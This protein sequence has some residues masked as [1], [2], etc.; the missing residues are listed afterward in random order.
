VE[1]KTP[2]KLPGMDGL[3]ST[4]GKVGLVGE[5]KAISLLCL[6]FYTTLFFLITLTA[7]TELPEWLPL[8]VGMLLI[9]AVA[10]VGV[11]AEWFWGRWFATGLAW[12]GVMIAVAGL[13]AVG[14]MPVLAIFG[15]LHLLVVLSLTGK[16][17]AA[18]YD[19]QEAWRAKYKMDDFGVARLQKTVTRSAAS[20]PSL[21]IWALAPKEEGMALAALL[22]ATAGVWGL[23]R[24][25]SWGVLSLG[26]AGALVAAEGHVGQFATSLPCGWLAQLVPH[27][28]GL[29]P[30]A[31]VFFATFSPTLAFLLLAAAVLPFAG[32]IVRYLRRSA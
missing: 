3:S 7:R 11:A 9:Y 12:S 26:A 14:W 27:V 10:F 30:N 15:T 21:I 6:G 20:L 13:V 5:R 18:R 4:L 25:R 19:L 22:L 31:Q 29:T 2:M 23:V 17:M 16:K 28:A 1:E 8:S 32:A 24:M